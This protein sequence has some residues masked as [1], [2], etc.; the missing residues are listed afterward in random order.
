MIEEKRMDEEQQKSDDAFKAGFDQ[1]TGNGNPAQET[2][3]E[4][5]K[6]EQVESARRQTQDS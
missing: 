1:V 4:E 3:A 6:T 5:P 2:V